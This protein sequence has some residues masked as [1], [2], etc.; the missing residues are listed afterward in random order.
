[1]ERELKTERIALRV[2]KSDLDE[3]RSIADDLGTDVSHV[4][5]MAIKQYK[6]NHQMVQS[7]TEQIPEIMKNNLSN[8]QYVKEV[9]RSA[10]DSLDDAD[11]KQLTIDDFQ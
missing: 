3:L 8:P 2:T 6:K 9:I 5:Y 10:D 4:V 7:L 1:M 11:E